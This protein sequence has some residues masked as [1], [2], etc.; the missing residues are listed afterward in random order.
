[1]SPYFIAGLS[2]F[3]EA[4][5]DPT[6]MPVWLQER[7]FLVSPSGKW[8]CK[9]AATWRPSSLSLSLP[10]ADSVGRGGGGWRSLAS[11][12]RLSGDTIKCCSV[13]PA[14]PAGGCY[15]PVLEIKT[16]AL[17]FCY[18]NKSTAATWQTSHLGDVKSCRSSVFYD[19]NNKYVWVKAVNLVAV[20]QPPCLM[21][22]DY[23]RNSEPWA[24]SRS[25]KSH[26]RSLCE[27]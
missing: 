18:S 21:A 22:A 14:R 4:P 15:S 26:G 27:C 20:C 25:A 13:S 7:L 9:D 10:P 24:W 23:C 1:M 12:G 16:N 11:P 19:Q 8:Q 17:V 2:L 3:S 6:S 5:G